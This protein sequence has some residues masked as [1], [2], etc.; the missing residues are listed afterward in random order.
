MPANRLT[1][2][3]LQQVHRWRRRVV[4]L[5]LV[6]MGASLLVWAASAAFVLALWVQIALGALLVASVV[7]AAL[8]M[9]RGRCPACG[10]R[11]RFAPRIEL[12]PACSRC[13]ASFLENP[14]Q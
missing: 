6:A 14:G 2:S 10:Q 8:T 4:H 1:Q 5:W 3:E 13:E 7:A 12:P 11:I 9:R